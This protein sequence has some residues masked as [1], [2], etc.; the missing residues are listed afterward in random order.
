M[1][2]PWSERITPEPVFRAHDRF[3]VTETPIVLPES[4]AT[5]EREYLGVTVSRRRMWVLVGCACVAFG[6][7]FARAA[8]LQIIA[9]DENRLRAEKNRVRTIPVPAIRGVFFDR[10]GKPLVANVPT[11]TVR[12]TPSDLPEDPA[13]RQSLLERL[14]TILGFSAAEFEAV[15][16]ESRTPSFVPVLLVQNVPHPMA[17]RLMIDA[18]SMPG[19]T[20]QYDTYRAYNVGEPIHNS[21]GHLFGYVGKIT[22][23]QYAALPQ[24]KY[25]L[26]DRI[27]REGLEATFED[28][29]RGTSGVRQVEVDALGREKRVVAETLPVDGDSVQLTIDADAQNKL[30]E[31]LGAELKTVGKTRGSAVAIDP[32]DGSVLALVSTPG[33]DANL[34]S[35]GIA[36]STYRYLL[37][38]EDAPLF[39]RAVAGVY[40]S[41]SIIKPVVAA[42]ALQE[43]VITTKTS[44]LSVGG[45][46][47]GEWFFPDW[48]AGGHGQTNVYKAIAESVNTF[49]YLIGGGNE[50]TIGL[51]IDRMAKYF[52]AFGFGEKTGIELPKEASGLVPTPDWKQRV[53]NEAWFIG[54]TYHAAIGQGDVLVTPLQMAVALQA[55]A[56]GGTVYA[57]RLEH[58]RRAADGTVTPVAVRVINRNM[59]SPETIQVVREGMRQTV[60]SGSARSMSALPVAVAGKTGTAQ[61]KEDHLP[62]GWFVGFAPYDAPE[63]LVV[64]M[65]EDAGEGSSVAVPVARQFLDWYFSR[66][67]TPSLDVE[68]AIE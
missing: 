36:S 58:A 56:N 26:N 51:G 27:G 16:A 37:G 43:G 14:G 17:V 29:L 42:A 10:T 7:L 31:L 66:S 67:S 9:G 40:P 64:V 62:H 13:E 2:F 21:W 6:V 50:T 49:F 48:K 47:Y 52:R 19:I 28:V 38:D 25:L 15:L 46:H 8:S 68:T 54:D 59:V 18:Q 63:I 32:R 39:P 24:G 60:L 55:F 23:E 45:I 53:K 11:F 22:A 41:G 5:G 44:F 3:D 33:Y 65:L 30:E 35:T 12:A 57:P 34:F 1:R 61:W 20:V 4:P